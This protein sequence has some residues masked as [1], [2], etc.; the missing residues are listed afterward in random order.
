[1]EIIVGRSLGDDE[2]TSVNICKPAPTGPPE[3]RLPGSGG[4]ASTKR[5]KEHG[6][7]PTRKLMPAIDE[8]VDHVRHH[9]E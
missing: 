4:N 3:T 9:P 2:A 1:M 5:F 6:E 7:R 8:A